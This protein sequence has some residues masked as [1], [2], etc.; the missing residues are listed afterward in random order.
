MALSVGEDVF[1]VGLIWFAT[2]HPYIAAG[3]VFIL[4]LVIIL[5]VRMVWR[6]LRELEQH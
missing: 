1:A 5:L 6:A 2:A 3:V 4:L